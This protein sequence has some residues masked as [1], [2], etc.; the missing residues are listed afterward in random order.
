MQEVLCVK[1]LIEK[2]IHLMP[3]SNVQALQNLYNAC[4]GMYDGFGMPEFTPEL[5]NALNMLRVYAFN[6]AGKIQN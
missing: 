6:T 3:K 5:Q 2:K 4:L 1:V